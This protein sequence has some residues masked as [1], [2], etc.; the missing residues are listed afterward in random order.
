MVSINILQMSL[1]AS[2]LIIFI[3]LLRLLAINRLPKITFTV[4]WG[5][6]LARLLIPFSVS[7]KPN[8]LEPLNRLTDIETK[9]DS[10]TKTLNILPSG[11]AAAQAI[12]HLYPARHY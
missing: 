9:V 1:S 4:L 7:L 5:I 12:P 11:F 2:I 8:F 3:V 10:V 6:V